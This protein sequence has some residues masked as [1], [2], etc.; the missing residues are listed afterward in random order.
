VID[1]RELYRRQVVA[2]AI[3]T[4]QLS[5]GEHTEVFVISE[6]SDD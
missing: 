5:P 6:N 2:I 3:S 1:E 4:P